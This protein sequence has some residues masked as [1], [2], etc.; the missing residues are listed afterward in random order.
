MDRTDFLFRNQLN[1]QIN[2]NTSDAEPA[3]ENDVDINKINLRHCT[4]S[5]FRKALTYAKDNNPEYDFRYGTLE[6]IKPMN[7]L[8]DSKYDFVLLTDSAKNT[9]LIIGNITLL[10]DLQKVSGAEELIMSKRHGDVFVDTSDAAFER[11][12][13]LDVN[14]YGILEEL[15]STVI[16][17]IEDTYKVTATFHDSSRKERPIVSVRFFSIKN[18]SYLSNRDIVDITNIYKANATLLEAF[19]YM[20]FYDYKKK[21]KESSFD[22]IIYSAGIEINGLE[23]MYNLHY[24]LRIFDELNSKK[25]S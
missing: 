4:Y 24:D 10:N 6:Q 13:S 19:A 1:Y 17:G 20:S 15:G 25:P 9:A 11:Y 18:N 8:E 16:T 5:E 7:C 3:S 2:L 23:D 21:R 14:D 22:S 12:M